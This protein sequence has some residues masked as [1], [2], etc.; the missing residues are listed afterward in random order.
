MEI[1]KEKTEQLFEIEQVENTPFNLIK[2]DERVKIIIGNQIAS[3]KDFPTFQGAK[4]YINSKPYELILISS[5]IYHNLVNDSVKQLQN[6][7][8]DRDNQNNNNNN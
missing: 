5:Y 6:F 2:Q 1:V 3:E 4:D 7:K 8:T